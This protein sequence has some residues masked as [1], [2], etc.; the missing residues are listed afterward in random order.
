MSAAERGS[1]RD[2]VALSNLVLNGRLEIRK[3]GTDAWLSRDSVMQ[4]GMFS[5]CIEI[6]PIKCFQKAT[7]DS[8]VFFHRHRC[9]SVINWR[10]RHCVSRACT[11]T[12]SQPT[13]WQP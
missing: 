6:L 8:L 4:T 2:A 1:R 10:L 5:K 9:V 13:P 3:G 7:N 11:P 12:R